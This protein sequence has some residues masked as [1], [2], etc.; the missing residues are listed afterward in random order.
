MLYLSADYFERSSTANIVAMRRCCQ[1]RILD[2][3]HALQNLCRQFSAL[4]N[5]QNEKCCI[6]DRYSPTVMNFRNVSVAIQEADKS[7]RSRQMRVSY[8]I[9]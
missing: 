5:F 8:P 1:Q 2:G 6:K 9:T 7:A 4:N 3:L